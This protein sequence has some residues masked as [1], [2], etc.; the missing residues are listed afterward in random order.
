MKQSE[1][2]AI[3]RADVNPESTLN[4]AKDRQ[5]LAEHGIDPSSIYQELEMDSP[6]VDT[7]GD[8]STSI[9]SVRL[10][11]H[12]F[13]EILFCRSTGPQYLL[14]ANRYRLQH[15]DVVYIP[16][17]VSHRPLFLESLAEPYSRYV[18]WA[19]P[20]YAA[21]L[22]TAFPQ[23]DL[24]PAEAFVLRTADTP[25]EMIGTL[26]RAGVEESAN[27]HLG[28]QAAVSSN[29]TM[30]LV[31]LLRARTQ[32]STLPPPEEKRELLD[33][34]LVFIEG[35]LA[36][37]ITL[38]DTARQFMVSESTIDQL[39][40]KRMKASFYHFVT[41]RRL[42]AAKTLLLDDVTAEQAAARTGFGDYSTFYRAFRREYG[43]SPAEY[44]RLQLSAGAPALQKREN[45]V[46]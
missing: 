8:I 17:G 43:I 30:L 45:G 37:K 36:E 1:M 15:G 25:Y 22:K 27:R 28:W 2:R 32:A 12:A 38:A 24:L 21:E 5:R 18:I 33:K 26:F 16:P 11:S 23:Q 3:I 13:Y 14:G 46:D 34:L 4:V 7:H 35:H 41:Q 39:F 9:D 44:R 19:S 31:Q 29:T 20:A 40:R 42:I 6:F 10:H